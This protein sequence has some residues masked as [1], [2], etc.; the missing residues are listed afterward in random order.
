MVIIFKDI[1]VHLFLKRQTEESLNYTCS[2]LGGWGKSSLVQGAVGYTL[3]YD[4]T[5]LTI[6]NDIIGGYHIYYWQRGKDI[7]VSDD[8]YEVL[9]LTRDFPVDKNEKT[10]FDR[11]NY[12]LADRTFRKGLYRLPPYSTL[13]ISDK[14]LFVNNNWS[15]GCVERKSDEF[16]YKL[17]VNEAVDNSLAMLQKNK[18]KILLCFSG[19]ADSL[20]LA[21]RM[22]KLGIDFEL[23]YWSINK[24]AQ[25]TAERGAKVL[26]KPLVIMD[27]SNYTKEL[28]DIVSNEMYFD[29]HYSRI[30]YVGCQEIVKKYGTNVV[31]VNGQNSD[32][33]LTFGPSETKF[34]SFWKRYLMYGQ[35]NFRKWIYKSIIEIGFRR[36]FF[37]PMTEEEKERAFL[38]N[39]KYCL[40]LD[41]TESQEYKNYLIEVINDIKRKI[42]FSSQNNLWMYL[43]LFTHIS[44][45]DSQVVINSARHFGLD[46]LMPFST[47]AFIKAALTYKDDLKELYSPKYAL[48]E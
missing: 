42:N 8:I 44:G 36:R 48:K 28:Q 26:G 23:L 39:F 19:G 10:Y 13:I 41:K 7:Y 34:T 29:H 11:H 20:Y 24:K 12:G 47:E 37:I 1:N 3:I 40:I 45:S 5:K 25:K 22:I 31:L 30:H 21:K 6:S 14:G 33:I 18:K 38:D 4:K 17:A 35:N 9:V 27:V 43:K 15:L 16:Q 46:L 32:S 2:S